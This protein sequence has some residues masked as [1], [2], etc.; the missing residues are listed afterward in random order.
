[1]K[2]RASFFEQGREDFF[3]PLTGPWRAVVSDAL[4]RMFE[5]FF[6][7]CAM[8]SH[9]IERDDLRALIIE[10]L[11]DAPVLA[12]EGR[13]EDDEAMSQK[14]ET[15]K[16]NEIIRRLR[17]CGW[18]E[19]FDDP[20]TRREVYRFTR[21][22]KLFSQQMAEYNSSSLRMTQR[23]VR[24]TKHALRAYLENADP[25]DL[26]MAH[27][28]AKHVVSD[29]AN[30]I[31]E[32]HERRKQIIA[33][34]AHEKAIVDFVEFMKGK[35]S[36]VMALKMRADNV[37]QHDRE[38]QETIS[39]I[40]ALAANRFDEMEKAARVFRG[41]RNYEGSIVCQTL[42]EIVGFLRDAMRNKM[43]ELSAAVAA[44][45]DRTS[46]LALQAS[47]IAATS[48]MQAIN[49][50]FDA[51]VALPP[52]KQD[53]VLHDVYEALRPY[54]VGLVDQS[55]IRLR[56]GGVRVP[57][58]TVQ[59]VYEPTREERQ[60]A[61]LQQAESK[62]F[63][64]SLKDIRQ[65]LEEKISE[66]NGNRNEFLISEIEIRSYD[67]LL[68]VTH[69]MESAADSSAGNLKLECVP[70]GVRR[71]NDYVEFEDIIVRV[72]GRKTTVK[73]EDHG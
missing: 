51:M 17:T 1:M 73:G 4:I 3:R 36:P 72:V 18:I 22:G 63:A 64:I 71:S 38:I 54:R 40:R 32:I 61:F 55:V 70:M 6:G 29:L 45:T 30:D 58:D 49:A 69:A 34:A 57:I 52:Q 59:E 25:Y 43:G 26:F 21:A 68:Y 15:T 27:E 67:D 56:R 13:T 16:A 47:I 53:L 11:Q 20:G 28:H 42:D 60:E 23:N 62:A 31:N 41:S 37:L 7:E 66:L 65:R 39:K 5:A 10:S 46:F 44:Y 14:D 35:F 9:C 8:F 24:N 2:V 50:A 19:I 48:G 12:D 33:E